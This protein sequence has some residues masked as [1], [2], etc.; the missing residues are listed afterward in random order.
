MEGEGGAGSA[1]SEGE[2][3][4]GG[5]VLAM[6]PLCPGRSDMAGTD[7]RVS[8]TPSDM[9]D[10]EGVPNKFKRLRSKRRGDLST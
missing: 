5:L 3:N 6:L 9:G 4:D 2:S 1:A 10:K 8:T 7:R